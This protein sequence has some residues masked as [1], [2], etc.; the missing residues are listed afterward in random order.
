MFVFYKIYLFD[1]LN[2][3]LFLSIDPFKN[4]ILYIIMDY[5]LNVHNANFLSFLFIPKSTHFCYFQPIY[6]LNNEIKINIS[7]V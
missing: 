6:C 4:F 7:L 5:E 1:S 3:I 2:G